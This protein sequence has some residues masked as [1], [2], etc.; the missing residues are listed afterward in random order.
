MIIILKIVELKC[1]FKFKDLIK[2]IQKMSDL[3][4]KYYGRIVWFVMQDFVYIV[5]CSNLNQD[6]NSCLQLFEVKVKL[7]E[8]E[9]FVEIYEDVF[10]FLKNRK[11]F[12]IEKIGQ[13]YCVGIEKGFGFIFGF[14]IIGI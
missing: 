1:I 8:I 12:E 3:I 10:F 11:M 5:C 6:V 9:K 4:Q 13:R 2:L 7:E 14:V